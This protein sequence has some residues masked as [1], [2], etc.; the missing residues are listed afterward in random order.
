MTP[1]K[2]MFLFLLFFICGIGLHSL[3]NHFLLKAGLLILGLILIIVWAPAKKDKPSLIIFLI[4][5]IFFALSLGL[6]RAD[7]PDWSWAVPGFIKNFS[8]YSI[9]K[10]Y[11][12]L[13][14]NQANLLT[15]LLLGHSQGFNTNILN[16]FN[17]VGVRHIMAVSG[18]H[19]AI[20]SSIVMGLFLYIGLWRKHAFYLTIFVLIGFVLLTGA[21]SSTVR[22]SIMAGSYFLGQNI[23]RRVKF[24]NI[25]ILTAVLMLAKDPSLL[26]NSIGFQL[27]FCAVLG[28]VYLTP[29]LKS[30]LK[31]LPEIIIVNLSAQIAVLPL[32]FYYFKQISLIAPLANL[33][34]L[35]LLPFLILCGFIVLFI[36]FASTSLAIFLVWPLYL[37]LSYVLKIVE[38]I[39]QIPGA[40][41]TF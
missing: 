15:G 38:L 18:Y 29:V 24:K 3:I 7:L 4:G 28:I 6:W 12:I 2:K 22:A 31:F 30:K 17:C 33:L 1:N 23:G 34:V 35:P 21:R 19:C 26:I 8:Q 36:G 16:Q 10:I 32:I 27:S 39:S 37:G 25:I 14:Y 13:P 40:C 5:L 9:D 20:I 41:L 11:S